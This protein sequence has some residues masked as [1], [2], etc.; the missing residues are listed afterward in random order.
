MTSA[1]LTSKASTSSWDMPLYGSPQT[2]RNKTGPEGLKLTTDAQ[3]GYGKDLH[4][5]F[6]TRRKLGLD[7]P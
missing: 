6:R 1:S 3:N 4:R 5:L 7:R 2:T